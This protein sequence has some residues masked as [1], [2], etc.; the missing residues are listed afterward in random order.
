MNMKNE[1]K[2]VNWFK[3]LPWWQ[4]ILVLLVGCVIAALFFLGPD[5]FGQINEN[6]SQLPQESILH[7]SVVSHFDQPWATHQGI[8]LIFELSHEIFKNLFYSKAS[9]Y[10]SSNGINADI[11]IDAIAYY[12]NCT[13][14]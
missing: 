11:E 3:I 2:D 10:N 1:D 12:T 13:K 7:V 6:K 4:K 5:A 9:S 14:T 8:G